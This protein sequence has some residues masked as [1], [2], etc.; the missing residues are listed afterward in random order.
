MVGFS[1]QIRA[2]KKTYYLELP[3]YLLAFIK[4]KNKL[5]KIYY[6][7]ENLLKQG[8]RHQQQDMFVDDDD[9][10]PQPEVLAEP[11]QAQEPETPPPPPVPE[12]QAATP[13]I[14]TL[15]QALA[16]WKRETGVYN[17]SLR[18]YKE[19]VEWKQKMELYDAS[20]LDL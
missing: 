7:K 4:R 18:E 20:L 12:P 8:A 16:E 5:G 13:K 11:P 6:D 1:L 14:S 15:A 9:D 10:P 3:N 19:F 2:D 17:V